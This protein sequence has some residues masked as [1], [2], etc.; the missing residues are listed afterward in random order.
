MS[1]DKTDYRSWFEIAAEDLAAACDLAATNHHALACFH[2]Q[3][4]AEKALKAALTY[5]GID[6]IRTHKLLALLK[7]GIPHF[8]SLDQFRSDVQLLDGY[9]TSTRYPNGSSLKTPKGFVD[10]KDSAAAIASARTVLEHINGLI[11]TED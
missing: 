7:S 3:Q 2:S 11:G 10:E 4:A 6:S 1:D 9:Y 8:P 5:T